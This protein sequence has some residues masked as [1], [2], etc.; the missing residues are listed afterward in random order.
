MP[1]FF[2]KHAK[3]AKMKKSFLDETP[4]HL[5]EIL[6]AVSEHGPMSTLFMPTHQRY[7]FGS[8]KV[9]DTVQ[10]DL[11]FHGVTCKYLHSQI[12]G[13]SNYYGKKFKRKTRDGVMHVMRT[14]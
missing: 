10:I 6:G 12:S 4:K 3:R 13:Y 2:E 1:V 7:G 9:G 8:L 5:A 14:E 11:N